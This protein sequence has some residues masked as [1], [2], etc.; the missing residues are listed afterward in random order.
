MQFFLAIYQQFSRIDSTYRLREADVNWNFVQE[1]EARKSRQK[2]HDQ[3]IISHV[4][5]VQ[6]QAFQII[7]C[8][9]DFQFSLA[10]LCSKKQHKWI[11]SIKI[12]L[13]WLQC[14]FLFLNMIVAKKA[15]CSQSLE[16]FF[17]VKLGCSLRL[18]DPHWFK[19]ETSL[20]TVRCRP[21]KIKVQ[22]TSLCMSWLLEF[23]SVFWWWLLLIDV[24]KVR[25]NF[26]IE[27]VKQIKKFW[28][29][30]NF[31]SKFRILSSVQ[32]CDNG[33]HINL[34]P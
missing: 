25:S 8:Q 6:L 32:Q 34:N 13:N 1:E 18:P 7:L 9:A 10:Q 31:I 24:M 12:D 19:K 23:W 30:E 17:F 20:P 15:K 5:R 2:I 33:V 21:R 29:V 4:F 16:C 28:G 3:M 26:M 11:F 14:W 22:K 27:G